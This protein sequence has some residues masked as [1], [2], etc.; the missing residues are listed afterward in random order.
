MSDSY[1]VLNIRGR[2]SHVAAAFNQNTLMV[3]GGF[4]GIS[5]GDFV[6]Y[7]IPFNIMHSDPNS[8]PVCHLFSQCVLC[9]TWGTQSDFQCGWCVQDS[10]CYQRDSPSGPCSTTT[11][12][13]GWWGNKG[14]FL[15][16][17]NQCRIQDTTPGLLSNISYISENDVRIINPLR[18]TFPKIRGITRLKTYVTVTWRGFIYPFISH[19]I[20]EPVSLALVAGISESA[21]VHLSTNERQI[22]K[23]NCFILDKV[24]TSCLYRH[25]CLCCNE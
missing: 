3:V 25:L 4:S 9:L 6:A 20:D 23:V 5:S 1:N 18:E 19:P 24:Y 10:T 16:S 14:S 12:T 11:T 21:S 13:R 22:D 17:I 7:K 15:T 2:Y 8:T